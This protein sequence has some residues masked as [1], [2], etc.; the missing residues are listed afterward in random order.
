MDEMPLNEARLVKLQGWMYVE[1]AF[2]CGLIAS[3]LFIVQAVLAGWNY[4]KGN[5]STAAQEL[6]RMRPRALFSGT[7]V[8]T[9]TKTGTFY[10]CCCCCC[11]SVVVVVVVV[12]LVV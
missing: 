12:D 8:T 6:K 11:C 2:G 3:V 1:I 7:T 9:E 5:F 10:F 4:F